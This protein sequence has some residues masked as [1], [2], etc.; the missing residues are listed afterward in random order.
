DLVGFQRR[1]PQP[2]EEV[3]RRD[4]PPA[5]GGDRLHLRVERQ[6]DGRIL[7]GGIGVRDRPAERSAATDLE[8]SDVRRRPGQQRHR[9][10]HLV[11]GAAGGIGGAG[12]DRQR[13]VAALDALE[14]VEPRDVDQVV[15]ERQPQIQH[16][17]QA[18]PAGEHL[19]LIAELGEQLRRLGQVGRP[20]VGERCGFHAAPPE[21]R[22]NTQPSASPTASPAATGATRL[23]IGTA[24]S[25]SMFTEASAA[26]AWVGA[27]TGAGC[28][29]GSSA[30]PCGAG[31]VVCCDSTSASSRSANWPIS[32]PATSASTP[33]PNW[34]ALPEMVRSVVR[35][36][37][38]L[39][40]S[41]LSSAV[42]TAA[43]LPWPR[44]SLPLALITARRAAVSF[45]S[46][47][48]LPLYCTV[49][50]P[51]F[52]LTWPV[53]SSP[54]TLSSVAPGMQGAM[55]STSVSTS[56]A[57]SAGTGTRNLLISST[58][59]PYW[60]LVRSVRRSWRGWPAVWSP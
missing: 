41:S 35:M 27:A 54:S 60:W 7:P 21:R 30:E 26:G 15:E 59:G 39:S 3:G 9:R 11:V 19:G 47:L 34:A 8:V 49:I 40:P 55:R 6:C 24:T 31:A 25:A 36:H 23:A 18:L 50:G 44:V 29:A 16:R 12:A 13:A 1:L 48:A 38:V 37:S 5:G 33:R 42:T 52:T 45:C 56:Q 2:L 28:T 57:C 22:P 46:K 51:T 4:L 53:K 32:L 17:D 14:L 10:A 20:V 43:A 58:S